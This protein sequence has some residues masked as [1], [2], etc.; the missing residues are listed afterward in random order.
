MIDYKPTL[1]TELSALGL[2]V[3][4]ENTMASN[5]TYPVITYNLSTDVARDTG[6]TLGYSDIYYNIK[7]WGKRIAEIE[8]IA[9]Q[10]DNKMRTLGFRR[11][12]TA[13]L[14]FNGICQKELRYRGLGRERF[15]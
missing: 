15:E 8:S 13:E 1:I 4:N 2:P 5:D 12:A 14:W 3:L 11:I 10:I 7:V 6:D 9:V